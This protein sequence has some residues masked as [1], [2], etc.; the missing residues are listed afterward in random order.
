[1]RVGSRPLHRHQDRAAPFSADSDTLDEP[2]DGEQHRAP[3]A[4]GRVRRN[5]GHGKGR[6]PHEQQGGDQR[7]FASDAVAI[8]AKDGGADG[9]CD[10]ADRVDEECLKRADQGIGVRK[11]EL[12]K[13]QPGD[14]AIEEKVVPLDGSADRARDDRPSQLSFVLVFSD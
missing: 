1:M 13:D 11:V 9:P 10:E 6:E 14:S 12:G 2:Q 7:R 8:M 5:E 4:Y 3:D